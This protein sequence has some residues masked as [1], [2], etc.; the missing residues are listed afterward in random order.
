MYGSKE[1]KSLSLLTRAEIIPVIEDVRPG[2]FLTVSKE[3]KPSLEHC[4]EE[5]EM[6]YNVRDHRS[7]NSRYL[8]SR[9]KEMLDDIFSYWTS[10]Y[11]SSSECLDYD[12]HNM[13]GQF[14][15]YPQCC[16]DYFVDG[17]SCGRM[18]GYDWDCKAAES[19]KKGN[20]NPVFN[21]VFHVPCRV[22]C[23]ESRI[24]GEKIKD[25]LKKYDLAAAER[26][27][28]LNFLSILKRCS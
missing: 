9:D 18:P 3:F 8:V 21:Y 4:I 11:D 2:A 15:G 10:V 7:G 13:M 6:L 22:N 17:C 28:S 27:K 16:I 25:V 24:L 23:K 14:F 19:Y 5:S 26:I 1:W 20:Y 12:Y